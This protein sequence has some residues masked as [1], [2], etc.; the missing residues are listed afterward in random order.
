MTT[1]SPDAA[2]S[3]PQAVASSSA[4][5]PTLPPS[6]DVASLGGTRLDVPD[7]D[8]M[9]VVAGSA[10]TTL[11][12]GV[13][14]QLDGE[15]GSPGME[16]PVDGPTCTA[17]DVGF[18]SLWVPVCEPGSV[19]R[20]DPTTGNSRTIDLAGAT[21]EEEGSIAAGEGSVWVVTSAPQHALLRI[22]PNRDQLIGSSPLPAGVVAV[23]AGLGGLWATDANRGLL[24]RLDPASGQVLTEIPVG[25]GAR[26]FDVG[27]GAVWV[28]NNTDGTV[29]RVDPATDQ[30]TATIQVDRGAISG[31][32][33][34][35]GGRY[36]WAR[37]SGSLVA[38]IDPATNLVVARIGEPEGSGS[39]AADEKAVWISAHDRNVVYRIPLT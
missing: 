12:R 33:L 39:V 19:V 38:Q 5:E 1:E 9:A 36:V 2:D 30:V 25:H 32:D 6:A 28:Q 3:S 22:D 4:T 24:L 13:V 29:S 34:A 35:V 20:I 26:F 27:E 31:G 7:A 8:W 18:G 17:P 23:R 21:I 11:G 15:D 37:V 14:Q 16:V 10:W